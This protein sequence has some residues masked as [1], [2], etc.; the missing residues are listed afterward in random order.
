MGN[1]MD[2]GSQADMMILKQGCWL[3][4]SVYTLMTAACMRRASSRQ[5]LL[6]TMLSFLF[7]WAIIH[8]LLTVQN[9]TQMPTLLAIR[10]SFNSRS[11][12]FLL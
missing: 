9:A 10:N 1:E 11:D 7:S 4:L 5:L 12:H 8:I 2:S 3:R 6:L